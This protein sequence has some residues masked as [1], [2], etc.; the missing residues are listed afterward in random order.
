MGMI[1]FLGAALMLVLGYA[2]YGLFVEKVF[3]IDRSRPTPA[4]LK[5]DG[6]DYVQLPSY[7]IFFVQLLN[8]AGLGPVFGPILGALYGPAAL[9]WVVFGCIFAGATHDFVSG[10][11][12]LR[13]RG[14]SYPEVIGRNLGPYVRWF[15]LIFTIWFMILVGAVFVNGPAGLLS[16]ETQNLLGRVSWGGDL[17]QWLGNGPLS[18]LFS[19][20]AGV[21]DPAA[22]SKILAGKTLA[23]CFSVLI[24]LY[25]FL[26]TI[27]PVDRIIG[28][29]YPF[30]AILL[31]FMTFGLFI[32]LLINPNYQVLPN[33]HFGD[34]FHNLHPKG[35][36]LWPLMF[37]TIACGAISGFH[38]TQSPMMARCMKSEG[39]ARR[40]FYGSMIA[41]GLIALVWVTI[42]LSFYGGDPQ[43]LMQAGPPAVVV[44]KTSEALLGGVVGGVLVFLGVVILPISTGDT[45]FRMGR[46]I[47][48]DVLHVQQ[49]NIQKRILLAIP[50]FIC[51][52]FFTVND[53]SA[54]WMA[55]GWANQ[56]FSCLTLWACAVWLKRRNKLHWIV[57]LPAFFMT[58]VCASYLFCYE[59]FPFGW[60]QWIS[61][62]LGLAVAGLCA[63]I[64]WKRGGIMPEGDEQEF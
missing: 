13:Y 55:F 56:T 38:A 5:A 20:P 63:G 26:A 41:E 34:F 47:L 23:L 40:I 53:F 7:K 9:L 21:T 30:F 14:A 51:G 48:A 16:F 17:L 62:L 60:P 31:L 12:S 36:P 18:G 52:I 58:T 11:M 43:T 59:K 29:I 25:Y 19:V 64:F 42:G 6:V 46:L 45:A 3:G 15:M 54:I 22:V 49:S 2:V 28:R 35:A 39:Q 4:Q 8:I 33:L 50:L 61:L 27:L 44:A 10:A 1:C 32:A 24:F 37:V 57:S